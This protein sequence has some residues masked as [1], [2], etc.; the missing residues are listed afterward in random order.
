L[1]IVAAAWSIAGMSFAWKS[2]RRSVEV[3]ARIIGMGIPS[4]ILAAR[5]TF[6]R[7]QS[8]ATLA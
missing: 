3:S 1:A 8:E 5:N 2:M 6:I 4:L 7:T